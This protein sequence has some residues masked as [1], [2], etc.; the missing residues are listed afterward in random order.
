MKIASNPIK[1]IK[2]G[3]LGFVLSLGLLP[4]PSSALDGSIFRAEAFGSCTIGMRTDPIGETAELYLSTGGPT[5]WAG[6]SI[7]FLASTAIRTPMT[8]AALEACGAVS[9]ITGLA[10]NGADGTFASDDYIG[11]SF[12]AT[13]VGSGD[14]FDYEFA[15]AGATATMTVIT[16]TP[17]VVTPPTP[18]GGGATPPVATSELATQ[19]QNAR[20][21]SLL[22][23]QPDLIG[24]L[25]GKAR[26]SFDA[27]VTRG[28]GSLKFSN[29][30]ELP[31][32]FHF[33]AAWSESSGR[34][35]TY[36]LGAVGAHQKI[37]SDLIVGG[38]LQFDYAETVDGSSD[39]D[40]SGWLFGPYFVA[41]LPEQPL[42]FEGRAL[43]GRTSNSVSGGAFD[44]DR[45]LAQFKVT[46]EIDRDQTRLFPTMDVSYLVEDQDAFGTVAAQRSTITQVELG[47]GF[48]HSIASQKGLTLVGGVYAVQ[49]DTDN[50]N[51]ALSPEFDGSRGRI[52]L[53]LNRRLANNGQLGID[54]FYDGIGADGFESFGVSFGF[55]LRF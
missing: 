11:V 18:G 29:A 34:E 38:M 55:D 41:K 16:M 54:G 4:L 48:E 47:L 50:A 33:S 10:Q 51:S 2:L 12:E 44:T 1:A 42:Y 45:M 46:G 17:V 43:Y 21:N 6:G 24:H 49:S 39:I 22:R 19:F 53:G 28:L 23:E 20:A 15:L 7:F 31:V 27:N 5:Q 35:T 26:G 30:G 25:S 8:V 9:G 13:D 14:R 52:E 32:W 36:A 37:N 3:T 40:G